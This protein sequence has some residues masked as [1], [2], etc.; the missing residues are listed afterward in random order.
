MH[1]SEFCLHAWCGRTSRQV[2]EGPKNKCLHACRFFVS[3]LKPSPL[4]KGG[5]QSYNAD[6]SMNRKRKKLCGRERIRKEKRHLF[7]MIQVGPFPSV[8]M[9]VGCPVPFPP[10]SSMNRWRTG[11]CVLVERERNTERQEGKITPELVTYLSRT[12]PPCVLRQSVSQSV[13]H[14]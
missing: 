6:Q 10:Y 1:S 12:V 14:D 2:N 13:R 11:A 7:L 8:C 4:Y 9:C 3:A 5:K